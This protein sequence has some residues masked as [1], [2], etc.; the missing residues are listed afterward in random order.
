M[1]DVRPYQTNLMFHRLL[2]SERGLGRAEKEKIE[3]SEFCLKSMNLIKSLAKS[4]LATRQ[5]KEL[6][7]KQERQ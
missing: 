3:K 7:S 4:V 1:L 5:I 6:D 2:Q